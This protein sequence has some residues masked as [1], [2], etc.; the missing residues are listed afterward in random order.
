MFWPRGPIKYEGALK[1]VASAISF[2]TMKRQQNL[3][4]FLDFGGAGTVSFNDFLVE[5]GSLMA[6]KLTGLGFFG[7]LG[8][9]FF[10]PPADDTDFFSAHGALRMRREEV[11]IGES[12]SVESFGEMLLEVLAKSKVN[13][14]K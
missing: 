9:F 12:D 7:L 8:A 13:K 11:D 2:G 4:W 1:S 6:S 3:A 14:F 10:S 5:G